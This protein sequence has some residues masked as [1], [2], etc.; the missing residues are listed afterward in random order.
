MFRCYLAGHFGRIE[1]CAGEALGV[2]LFVSL[3]IWPSWP[4]LIAG[5][6]WFVYFASHR[7]EKACYGHY[8]PRKGGE[9]L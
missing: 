4:I 3:I 5:A 9:M 2:W 8:G 1:H 7:I 6:L